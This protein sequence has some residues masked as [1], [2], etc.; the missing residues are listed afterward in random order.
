MSR[1]SLCSSTQ[2]PTGMGSLV[3]TVCRRS[4]IVEST[5]EAL[6]FEGMK[7]TLALLV[8]SKEKICRGTY[9]VIG[10]LAVTPSSLLFKGVLMIVGHEM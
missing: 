6:G 5:V 3:R 2:R 7:K 8:C 1:I 9:P 4:E 10:I